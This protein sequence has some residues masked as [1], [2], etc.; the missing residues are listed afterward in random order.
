LSAS[1]RPKVADAGALAT[2]V[3]MLE[4]KN[5]EPNRRALMT[6]VLSEEPALVPVLGSSRNCRVAH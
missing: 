6:P 4:P 3:S 5:E 2:S 1:A